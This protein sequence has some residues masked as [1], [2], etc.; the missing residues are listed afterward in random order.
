[1][2]RHPMARGKRNVVEDQTVEVG[3]ELERCPFCGSLDSKPEVHLLGGTMYHVVCT[4]PLCHAYGPGRC[5]PEAAIRS[6]NRRAPG[7]LF[8]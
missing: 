3:Q 1:M 6:W 4:N 8:G 7:Y 2:R 5:S